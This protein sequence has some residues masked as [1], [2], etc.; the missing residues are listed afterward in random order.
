LGSVKF[1]DYFEFAAPGER[2]QGLSSVA[3]APLFVSLVFMAVHIAT[4]KI[5]KLTFRDP[6]T[7]IDDI[8]SYRSLLDQSDLD[9]LRMHVYSIFNKL[10]HPYPQLIIKAWRE[11][12][13]RVE[14]LSIV[15]NDALAVL[16]APSFPLSGVP[17]F[18][19]DPRCP[20]V[21]SS[22]LPVALEL[23]IFVLCLRAICG[24]REA[25]SVVALLS[26]SISAS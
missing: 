20:A 17:W 16:A 5:F 8:E 10:T 22:S 14:K 4:T 18:E 23:L 19:C 2:A 24:A 15:S 25:I 12:N 3:D 21:P 11:L 13:I 26:I 1:C 9:L 7:V 6:K